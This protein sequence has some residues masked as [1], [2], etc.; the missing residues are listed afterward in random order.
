MTQLKDRITTCVT[1]ASDMT[2]L[3][4]RTATYVTG[5]RPV[6]QSAISP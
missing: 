5:F 4:V 1:D 3:K 2:Q 6:P